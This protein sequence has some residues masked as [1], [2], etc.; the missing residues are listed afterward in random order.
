MRR[1]AFTPDALG[2]LE[3]RVVL[4]HVAGLSQGPVELS[5]L[6]FNMAIGLVKKDFELFATSGDLERLRAML[7]EHTKGIPFHQVDGL[8]TKVDAILVQMQSDIA[9]EAPR[10]I[11]TSHHRVVG[12]I[13]ADVKARID[14]GSIVVVR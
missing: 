6:R 7:A 4:S 2:R 5:D 14:D 11:S 12:A 9:S 10:P 8:G 13:R 3:D 1:R